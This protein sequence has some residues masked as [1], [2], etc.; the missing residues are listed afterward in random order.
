[1]KWEF[2]PFGGPAEP[3][4]LFSDADFHI[5]YKPAGLDSVPVAS[6]PRD[7]LIAWMDKELPGY[8]GEFLGSVSG[9]GDMN[10]PSRRRLEIDLG[11]LSRLDRD[12]SGIIVFARN[13]PALAAAMRSQR[14]GTFVK[15]YV[16][17][18][19]ASGE[20][21]PGSKPLL[22]ENP[23]LEGIFSGDTSRC[24]EV[25]GAFR[26]F[27]PRG[28]HVACLAAEAPPHCGGKEPKICRTI[29]R[30]ARFPEHWGARA[31]NEAGFGAGK[32]PAPIADGN[33]FLEAEI[34]AGFRHQIRA[35]M[36]WAGHPIAGD[37]LYGGL[38]AERLRLES[39]AVR[40]PLGAGRTLFFDL[41]APDLP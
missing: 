9:A 17:E 35:H 12:T 36:A 5:I 14:D 22:L 29:L 25:R 28:A 23:A 26:S 18:A 21:L 15:E 27:G 33:L 1:M 11:M 16:L 41:Y 31:A 30:A 34:S 37:A 24:A 39:R 6:S 20:G 13:F 7:T 19:C 38:P 10:A 8:R 32:A 3:L 2:A 40:L 4:E